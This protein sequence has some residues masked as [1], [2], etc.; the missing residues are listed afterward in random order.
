MRSAYFQQQWEDGRALLRRRGA[1][2]LLAIA[3][4]ALILIAL[5]TLWPPKLP[6]FTGAGETV[7]QLFNV[8]EE[9]KPTATQTEKQQQKQQTRPQPEKRPPTDIVPP[10]P[11]PVPVPLTNIPGLLV[12][13]RDDYAKSD[14]SR[15]P[16]K[17]ASAGA[18]GQGNADDSQAVGTAP[19]GEPL[20]QA[21][22]Y[23]EPRDAELGPYLAKA[24]SGAPGS[25][26]LIA[27]QTAERYRVENC[28]SLGESPPGSGLA[29][30]VREAAW[31]FQVIPPR[32]G[33]KPLIGAWVR[34]RIDLTDA[35][36]R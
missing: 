2:L 6:T 12:L 22:W 15:F 26:G 34:I 8:G 28:Q 7:L 16:S 14:I 29:Y 5:L 9:K 19:N 17:A 4:E 13:S 36:T 35:K 30:S 32:K 1:G 25:W 18:A 31:Q 21:Q 11:P 23:R 24:R 27:C 33:G 10:T 3:V 20:Y